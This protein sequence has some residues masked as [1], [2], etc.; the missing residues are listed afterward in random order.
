MG[1]AAR[2]LSP[3]AHR[4]GL[5]FTI[6][7]GAGTAYAGH[8]IAEAISVAATEGIDWIKLVIQVVLAM[9]VIA[10]VGG[11]GSDRS[12]SLLRGR[13]PESRDEIEPKGRAELLVEFSVAMTEIV[14]RAMGTD[15][16]GNREIRAILC[17]IRSD[18]TTL[19]ALSEGTGMTKRAVTG[20]V[21]DLEDRGL[22]VRRRNPE[23]RRKVVVALT[24][25]GRDRSRHMELELHQFFVGARPLAS[26]I[27]DRVAEEADLTSGAV[28]TADAED[29]GALELLD[30]VVGA[31]IEL[32][33][34]VEARTNGF[35]LTGHNQPALFLVASGVSRPG[36]LAA[37]LAMSS[38]GMT[39]V[40]DQLE[41]AGLV[42]RTYGLSEDRRAVQVRTTSEGDRVVQERIS[43]F[44]E[45]APTLVQVF[46]LVR[47]LPD[48]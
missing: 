43:A 40:I 25:M 18:A 17:L 23:D 21:K 12:H 9:V 41:D 33:S 4:I 26:R 36:D 46:S 16:A 11:V 28:A 34:T 47:D 32:S 37:A 22:V 35:Q 8:G 48:P 1:G 13:S 6:A 24:S 39:Y 30:R 31:G 5:V 20:L 7:T 38:G 27:V 2:L 10:A 29:V 15:Y 45:F 44:Q 14:D 19:K 3:G 42:E